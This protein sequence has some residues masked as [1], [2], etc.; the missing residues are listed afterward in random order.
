MTTVS[1]PSAKAY[2][3]STCRPDRRYPKEGSEYERGIEQFLA[4]LM[5]RHI[6]SCIDGSEEVPA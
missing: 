6:E 5:E 2:P 3:N 1:L 4:D